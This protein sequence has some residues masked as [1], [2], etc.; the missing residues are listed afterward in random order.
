MLVS[1]WHR[2]GERLRFVLPT[3]T[4]TSAPPTC[5]LQ[6]L[7]PSASVNSRTRRRRVLV[8]VCPRRRAGLRS[9]SSSTSVEMPTPLWWWCSAVGILVSSADAWLASIRLHAPWRALRAQHASSRRFKPPGHAEASITS[10]ASVALLPFEPQQLPRSNRSQ[11]FEGWFVRLVDDDA[12]ASVALILGSLRKRRQQT[13]GRSVADA[14]VKSPPEGDASTGGKAVLQMVLESDFDE[15]ILVLAYRDRSGHHHMEAVQMEGSE[16]LLS[17]PRGA[18][19]SGASSQGPVLRWWSERYGGM[20]VSGDDAT[21]DVSLPGQLRLVANVS[22]PRVAWSEASPN[23]AGPEGWLSRTGL[24][25]CHYF[26]H[27]FASP[28]TYVLQHGTRSP[29]RLGSRAVA[30]MERNYGEAFPTGYTWAQA[31]SRKEGAFLVV[32]G[33][34]F[35]VGPLTTLTYIIGLRVPGRDSGGCK[36]DDPEGHEGLVGDSTAEGGGEGSEGGER[37]GLAWDFR[38]TDLDSVRA[39]RRPCHGTL[40]LNATSRDGRRRLLLL[41]AAPPETFGE[42]MPIP[43]QGGFSSQPGCRESYAATAHIV[44]L[45]RASRAS[46]RWVQP[47]RLSVPL[48][49]LEFGGSWQ[50]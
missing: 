27:S 16:V 4:S 38:T 7:V 15:H 48:A 21:I 37:G 12:G 36:A 42:P 29:P 32:T 10:A 8:C 34:L 39:V 5:E 47:L 50:C 19:D 23:R 6:D 49:A 31:S 20:T 46:S 25:P 2:D 3:A 35:V 30:H 45:R 14:D 44:A 22:G 9:R 26:V 11:W 41:L 1:T 28:T 40:S 43:T 17:G 13:G 18:I 33:G 24:L